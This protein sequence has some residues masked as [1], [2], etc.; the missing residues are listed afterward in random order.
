MELICMEQMEDRM[1]DMAGNVEE[2]MQYLQESGS[3]RNTSGPDCNTI[4]DFLG[5]PCPSP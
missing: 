4:P 5:G 1:Y 3:V 2:E